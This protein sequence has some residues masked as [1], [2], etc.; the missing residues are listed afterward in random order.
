M[1][2]LDS[3]HALIKESL[4]TDYQERVRAFSSV[5]CS[6][7]AGTP[8]IYVSPEFENHTGYMAAEVI[9]RTLSFLHGPETEPASIAKF[10]DL[11][12]T[13]TPGTVQ[14]TNYRKD[15]LPFKHE[16]EMRPI[17]ASDGT[18]THFVAVQT[19]VS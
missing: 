17:R 9:G 2:N 19:P 16:C 15:G 7:R 1:S 11:I 8:V 6:A 10:R 13:G 4:P 3:L 14:I 12:A 5:I 18:L